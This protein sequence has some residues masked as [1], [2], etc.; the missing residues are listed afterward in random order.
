MRRQLIGI[1]GA[2]SLLGLGALVGLVS[3]ASPPAQAGTFPG[4]SG[5]IAFA[6]V[7]DGNAE[8]YSMNADGTGQINL[9][10]NAADDSEPDW[11]ADGTKIVFQSNRDGNNEIYFMNADGTGQT[12]VTNNADVDG[13]GPPVDVYPVWSPDGTKI[14]FASLRYGGWDVYSIKADGTDETNLTNYFGQTDSQPSW[15]PDGTKIAFETT[16]NG[17]YA[18]Y[19]MDA[20]DGG[21]QTRLTFSG[22]AAQQPSW[23]PDG[24]KI[25]FVS[26]YP[27]EVYVMDADGLGPTPLTSDANSDYEPK[28]SPDGTQIAFQTGREGD[29]EIYS[30]NAADG[31]GQT[32]LT[33]SAGVDAAPSWGTNGGTPVT[34]TTTEPP[35]TTTLPPTTTTTTTT[36]PTTTTTTTLPPTTTTTLPPTTTTTTTLP[37]TLAGLAAATN[38]YVLSSGQPG[39]NG[40]ATSLTA[41]LQNGH[42][43]NYIKRVQKEVSKPHSTL[44]I[45]QANDLIAA[46]RTLDPSCP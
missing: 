30:M 2:V 17:P 1:I 18:I 25:V 34:T 9:T 38:Q 5:K 3:N 10:N 45:V 42:V 43:C 23:S 8:V 26:G 29:W 20:A 33:N 35:T 16:R 32:N 4:T 24:T 44:T 13:N 46:A 11:S 7:R 28:W 36:T 37:P 41:Q 22:V 6:T 27:T 21:N 12:R 40:V 39:A 31:S 14:A 19:V 15:S